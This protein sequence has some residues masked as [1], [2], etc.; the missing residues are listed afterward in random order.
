MNK[1]LITLLILLTAFVAVAQTDGSTAISVTAPAAGQLGSTTKKEYV[2]KESTSSFKIS[3]TQGGIGDASIRTV[4][5]NGV[6]VSIT[7]GSNTYSPTN[8][9]GAGDITQYLQVLGSEVDDVTVTVKWTTSG[10]GYI[11]L[12]QE[13]EMSC[14]DDTYSIYYTKVMESDSYT[15]SMTPDPDRVCA[16]SDA[17]LKFTLT[18]KESLVGGEQV[19]IRL[20]QFDSKNVLERDF[21]IK[22]TYNSVS[23]NGISHTGVSADSFLKTGKVYTFNVNI[24]TNV[25]VTAE[26]YISLVLLED[27][28]ITT[29]DGQIDQSSMNV[30]GIFR[31]L[32]DGDYG[33]TVLP[34]PNT[35]EITI[36]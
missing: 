32:D 13:A 7:Q 29:S 26:E 34:L 21:N 16:G 12:R 1:I 4:I 25:N 33:Y 28:F 6:L 14:F 31:L 35:S 10:E 36:N 23:I 9:N 20:N 8:I 2:V 24:S 27:T 11:A 15:L 3:L 22:L 30:T 17:V 18:V 5:K 19:D